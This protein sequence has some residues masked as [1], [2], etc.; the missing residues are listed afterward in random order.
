[1]YSINLSTF[2]RHNSPS[3]SITL[4]VISI[5]APAS[6]SCSTI[7]NCPFVAAYVSKVH[8]MVCCIKKKWEYQTSVA[9]YTLRE[10]RRPGTTYTWQ[11]QHWVIKSQQWAMYSRKTR[12]TKPGNTLPYH[13]H[14]RYM[15][16]IVKRVIVVDNMY[17]T[18]LVLRHGNTGWLIS[19]ADSSPLLSI[20]FTL[21]QSSHSIVAK[22]FTV[23]IVISRYCVYGSKWQVLFYKHRYIKSA[24]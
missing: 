12:R 6:R 15:S 23:A 17:L 10:E 5:L 24:T 20:S 7:A 19:A 21:S 4:S 18:P 14:T 3:K 9:T 22:A 2:S 16:T 13:I 1:M 8:L 11:S